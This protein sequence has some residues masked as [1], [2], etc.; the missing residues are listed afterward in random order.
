[1]DAISEQLEQEL[2][3]RDELLNR[4]DDTTRAYLLSC[5]QRDPRYITRI[6]RNRDDILF[7]Q[8]LRGE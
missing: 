2:I 6:I 1:M 4:V 5:E 7:D 8:Q 3:E